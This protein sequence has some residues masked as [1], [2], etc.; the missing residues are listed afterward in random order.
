MDARVRQ[1]EGPEA[2]PVELY[3]TT[4]RDGTQS[5]QVAFSV[6]DKVRVAERL[7]ALGIHYIE[8]GWPGANPRD[9]EFF[10]QVAK[11]PFFRDKVVAFGATRHAR[12]RPEADPNL[13]A[14]LA[15]GTA[16]ITIF[17]KTW[18]LHVREAL[19]IDLEQNLELIADSVAYLAARVERVFFDAEHFFDG[20]RANPD[21][22]L[23]CLRA[24]AEAGAARI[25]LCDTN[26]GTLPE[27]VRTGV[28]AART[29]V[30]VPLGIHAHNDAELAVANSLAA[31]EA[32]ATQVHGT[33]NG[34][35]ERCGNANL[36][37]VI[38]N[39][40]L[41]LGI[42]CIG[43]AQ[44]ASLKST[45]AFVSELANLAPDPRLPY[46]GDAAFAHKGGVHVS[47]VRRNPATY[48]H[49]DPALVGNHQRVLVS[50]LAGKGNIH[51]KAAEY[52]IN[53]D[54]GS[55][56]VAGILAHLKQLE[57]DGYQFEGA[58]ASFELLVRRLTDRWHDPFQILAFRTI[59]ERYEHAREAI[60]EATVRVA[61]D[62][63]VEHTVASGAGPVHA[64]DRALRRALERFFP[65]LSEVR[66]LDYKV[67]V[68]ASDHGTES[69]VRVL[70]ESGDGEARWG[71]VGVSA[72][73][74]DASLQALVDAL[75]FKL[76]R[77]HKRRQAEAGV[78]AAEEVG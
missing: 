63:Q 25:V 72:N 20:F 4:L 23:A 12:N 9:G 73:V 19:K 10:E 8:G 78:A 35:G 31:V 75:E 17:G 37:S 7:D 54:A 52:G 62:G 51:M 14:L 29:A 58:E 45:S 46:V 6:V 76:L 47:A 18:D 59:N 16:T 39:L 71:T 34:V 56:E 42:D 69:R 64:I 22:A 1:P 11:A 27:A 21:Y 41:K 30:A 33:I 49:V 70:V 26:G 32:G 3:D 68:L 77:E 36:C 13:A 66:L 74:V 50:D 57:A 28:L 61:V 24:A 55:E 40:K 67:R 60:S 38:P 48:E 53:L 65:E 5:V 2:P 15:A 44:L 43:D